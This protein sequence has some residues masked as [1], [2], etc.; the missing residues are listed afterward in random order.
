MER[1]ANR[2]TRGKWIQKERRRTRER[3]SGKECVRPRERKRDRER[4]KGVKGREQRE[5]EQE[6]VV[7]DTHREKKQEGKK[8]SERKKTD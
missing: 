8:E 1:T 3:D 4:N 6:G 5:I 7:R 2:D